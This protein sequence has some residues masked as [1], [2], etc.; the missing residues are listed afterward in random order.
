[1]LI[2]G[3]LSVN[4]RQTQQ[5]ARFARLPVGGVCARDAAQ[6]RNLFVPTERERE[7]ESTII[8]AIQLKACEGAAYEREHDKRGGGQTDNKRRPAEAE[9]VSLSLSLSP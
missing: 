3:Q 6:T 1:M 4:F 7:R 5:F 8:A 9:A 2:D